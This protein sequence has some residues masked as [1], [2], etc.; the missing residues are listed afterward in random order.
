MTVD[1]LLVD[2]VLSSSGRAFFVNPVQVKPYKVSS[3]NHTEQRTGHLPIWLVPVRWLDE[4]IVA[5][6]VRE[7]LRVSERK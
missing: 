2:H 6:R 5:F 7:S 1:D 4:T 3:R